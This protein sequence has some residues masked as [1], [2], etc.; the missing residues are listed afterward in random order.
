MNDIYQVN[1]R[2]ETPDGW[3]ALKHLSIK[4]RDKQPIGKEH[5]RHFQRIKNNLVGRECEA[6]ELYP[7][8]SRL[9]D[10]ANQYHLWCIVDCQIHLPFGFS[11]RLVL[12]KSG[13]GAVQEPFNA[14]SWLREEP[15]VER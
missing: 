14:T 13:G 1:I 6:V 3:P 12:S 4:R 15:T 7:A 11:E 5:F 8:E 2:N 10:T 9:V